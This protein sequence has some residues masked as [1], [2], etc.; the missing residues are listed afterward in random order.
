MLEGTATRRRIAISDLDRSI[1]LELF[2]GTP[3]SAIARE[4]DLSRYQISRSRQ[5]WQLVLRL[6]LHTDERS[7]LFGQP[8]RSPLCCSRER[9]SPRH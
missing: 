1:L 9:Q 2:K 4:F 7:E 8:H 5:K 3:I 6:A